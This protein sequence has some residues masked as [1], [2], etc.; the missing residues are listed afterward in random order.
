MKYIFSLLTIIVLSACSN[1]P[2]P[3]FDISSIQ[4]TAI[5][6]AST[7]ISQT[8]T[9]NLVETVNAQGTQ[10]SKLSQPTIAITPTFLV[11]IENDENIRQALLKILAQ[12]K[13]DI[14]FNTDYNDGK[15]AIGYYYR[16]A[17][18]R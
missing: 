10:I 18:P 6:I 3:N 8:K 2:T 12:S 5:A 16:V 15:L 14:N 7:N 4:N 9:I 17:F 11:T 1:N 13:S